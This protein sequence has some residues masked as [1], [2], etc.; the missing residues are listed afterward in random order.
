MEDSITK[1][2]KIKKKQIPEALVT[3]LIVK[4]EALFT[5]RRGWQCELLASSLSKKNDY[6]VL[7]AKKEHYIH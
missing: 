3:N 7:A 1:Q 4:V 2:T 5:K 6:R